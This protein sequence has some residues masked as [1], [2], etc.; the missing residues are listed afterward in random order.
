MPNCKVVKENNEVVA[1][2]DV[3]FHG[4]PFVSAL[5]CIGR[6][7]Y[8]GSA[9]LDY[10]KIENQLELI[11]DIKVPVFYVHWIEY[12]CLKGIFFETAEQVKNYIQN[13]HETFARKERE[14]DNEKGKN[15]VYLKK[16]YSP[17]LKMKN[18]EDFV[19]I[20]KDLVLN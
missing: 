8:E 6:Y 2:F 4:A 16:M 15:S 7:C 10:K 3:K 18:F 5:Q 17:L 11:K 19:K 20:L 1:Y 9:T 13:Q 12:P 14:G